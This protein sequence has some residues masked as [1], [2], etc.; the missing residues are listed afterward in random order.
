MRTEMVRDCALCLDCVFL[1]FFFCYS[2]SLRFGSKS[3]GRARSD[4][5]AENGKMNRDVFILEI[6]S[7]NEVKSWNGHRHQPTNAR[8]DGEKK[9]LEHSTNM[10]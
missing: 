1:S 5:N 10:L 8:K 4:E 3:I 7:E 9:V 2:P 6:R